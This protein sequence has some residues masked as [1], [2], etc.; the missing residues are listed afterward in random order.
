V[1]NVCLQSHHKAGEE[2]TGC[3]LGLDE[4]VISFAR[5]GTCD[6]IYFCNILQYAVIYVVC[7]Y[8]N[9][10]KIA[11]LSLKEKQ[12]LIHKPLTD[13]E[14]IVTPRIFRSTTLEILQKAKQ[15]LKS[16]QS[17]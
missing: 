9:V 11:S 17:A 2:L 15:D 4:T 14:H 1:K 3:R 6:W 5:D 8:Y 7:T 16:A 13:C 12:K 10:K